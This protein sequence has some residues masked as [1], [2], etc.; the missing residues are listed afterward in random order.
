MYSPTSGAA[1]VAA[2]VLDLSGLMR[3][4]FER[5][6]LLISGRAKSRPHGR[7]LIASAAMTVVPITE[8][9]RL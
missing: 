4:A 1:L 9:E 5:R 7:M 8:I 3:N 2:A 6:N